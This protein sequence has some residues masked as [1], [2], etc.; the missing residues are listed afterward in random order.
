V[1]VRAVVFDLW[2]TL[3]VWPEELSRDFRRRWA[4]RI[5]RSPEEI[6]AVWY[7]AGAY[8]RRESGPIAPALSSVHEALGVD[9]VD[10][11]ELVGWRVELA[12][13]AVI[14]EVGVV[15]TL[16]ELRRRGFRVG[17]ISNCTEEVALVWT[18]TRF[19]PLFDAAV[20]SATAGCMKPDRRIYEQV[21][22]ELGVEPSDCLFVG[23][24][25]N[26]ELRGA[27]DVGMTPVLIHAEG[28]DPYWENLLDWDGLRITSIPQVLELVQ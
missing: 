25:A 6:D 22:A 4:S 20:L 8:E 26:D 2:N 15:E 3:A 19:A 11:D 12:R 10:L 27:R 17:L 14:P 5:G 1:L 7:A 24:G 16:A 21:C 9:S 28:E 13:Q 23:D 18:E